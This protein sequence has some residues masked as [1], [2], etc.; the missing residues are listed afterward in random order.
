MQNLLGNFSIK[1]RTL[2]NLDRDLHPIDAIESH[3]PGCIDQLAEMNL[4]VLDSDETNKVCPG[5]HFDGMEAESMKSLDRQ[6]Q[7]NGG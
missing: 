2:D 1:D 5:R 3:I 7:K 4:A 6:E